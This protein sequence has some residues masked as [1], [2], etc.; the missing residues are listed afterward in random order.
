LE[1]PE[2]PSSTGAAKAT[3]TLSQS[4]VAGAAQGVLLDAPDL[5]NDLG[6]NPD[7]MERIEHHQRVKE[8]IMNCVGIAAERIQ[9]R[10][11]DV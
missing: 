8:A 2:P 6:V 7:R 4:L 1:R 5:V 10:V 3:A 11:I 9:R